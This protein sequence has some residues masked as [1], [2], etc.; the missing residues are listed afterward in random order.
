MRM[1]QAGVHL[2]LAHLGDAVP[3]LEVADIEE[4]VRALHGFVGAHVPVAEGAF[5]RLGPFVQTAHVAIVE[6]GD[7]GLVLRVIEGAHGFMALH[8]GHGFAA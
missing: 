7:R 6:Q 3:V 8:H 2:E 4:F 1:A 5:D